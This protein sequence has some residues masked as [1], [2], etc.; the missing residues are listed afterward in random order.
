MGQQEIATTEKQIKS[1]TKKMAAV[2]IVGNVFLAVFKLLAGIFGHSAAMLSDSIHT[3]S[4]VFATLIAYIGVTVS[5]K[6]AD[7]K[8]PYGHERLECVAS[9]LL[10]GILFVTGIGI[11]FNCIRAIVDGSY[12]EALVPGVL[13]VIAAI[14]SIVVKEAMFWYTMYYAKKLRSS[15]FKADAW[16]HRSDALSSIGALVGIVGARHGF[17]ILDQIAGIVICLM[18]L[19]VAVGIFNDA[20]EKMLD[21][22]CDEEFEKGLKEFVIT[23]AKDTK[24]KIGIDLIRTRKFGEKIYIEMEIGLCGDMT[25]REAHEVAERLHDEVEKAYPDVKHV[26]IHVNPIEEERD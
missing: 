18:I 26:M 4:D 17:P 12:K 2:G 19:W 1:A 5:R 15:A 22:A 25:L 16:H 8:H 14:V 6:E 10:S 21:T 13:A 11:G 23:F 24:Q 9:L 7:G 20:V 3:L